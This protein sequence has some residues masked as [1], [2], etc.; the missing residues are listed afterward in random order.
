MIL[1]NAANGQQGK[2]LVPKLLEGGVD[3]RACVRSDR[4]AAELNKVG[5]SDVVVGDI[6]D[7]QVIA[8]AVDGIDTIYHVC[9]GI[10]PL[11]RQIGLAWIDAAKDA[12]VRHFVF[13]SVLHPIITD[14]VQHEIKRDIEEHLVSSGLE[15]TIL[16]PT[17]YMAP[18]R[19]RPVLESGE[20]KVGWSLERLQSLVD[21]G[22]IADAAAIVLTGGDRHYGATYE[23]VGPGR[24]TAHDMVAVMSRVLGRSI[25]VREVDAETYLA[26]LF[27][28]RDLNEIPHETSVA[29]SLRAR[30]SSHDFIGNPNV[31]TWLLGR[32]PTT[33]EQFVTALNTA[34]QGG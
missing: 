1:V 20:L 11:E 31:L 6:S 19:F 2:L 27:G 10:Q 28:Q 34:Q 23:L 7:P 22:D 29:R 12:G 5:V 25:G 15:Y 30:Y 26:G 16:Q 14:L 32:P 17:I 9:P 18:R 3:V 4:S 8:R 33:F 24:Y 21:I 13:S